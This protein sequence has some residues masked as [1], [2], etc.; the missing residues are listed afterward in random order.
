MVLAIYGCGGLGR[1]VLE[2]SKQINTLKDQWDNTV[3]IYDY[4]DIT[5]VMNTNVY[6]LD[7]LISTYNKDDIEVIIAVGD[8]YDRAMLYEKIKKAKFNVATLIHPTVHIP[9]SAEISEGV[10][11]GQYALISVNV[12]IGA[13]SLI[14]NT[15]SIGHDSE[16]GSN[17]VLS[18]FS[19]IA[20]KCT[21]GSNTYISM[22]VPVKECISIGSGSIIGM[23][24][25]VLRDIPDNVVALG[26]PARPM[27]NNDEKKV[28]K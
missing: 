7:Q 18:A 8:P 5:E 19:S 2:L 15:C 17:C 27:K 24:S 11:I 1:E 9:D 3:F 28:F 4:G 25:V 16:I 10:I 6:S 14:Q 20:G 22:N 21:V 13:N 26:N 12:R 23:G